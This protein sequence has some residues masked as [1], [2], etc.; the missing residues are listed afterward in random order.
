MFRFGWMGL[1]LAALVLWTGLGAGE[2]WGE[3]S[4]RVAGEQ[5]TVVEDGKP[6]FVLHGDM[7]AAPEGVPANF[8]RT[9]YLH[10]LYGL[11]GEVLTEDFPVDHRHH[12]GV[13]W[14]W[15]Q[16]MAGKRAMDVWTLKDARQVFDGWVAR[17][18]RDGVAH[19]VMRNMWVFDDAP[20]EPVLRETVSIAVHP[21]TAVGRA[22]DFTIELNNVSGQDF[23]LLGAKDK[24]YG[25]FCVRPPAARKPMTFTTATG[26]LTED[27]LRAATPWADV[28]F[29]V[30]AG[31]SAKSGVAI[32]QHPGNPAYPHDGWLMRH[33]SF[34]GAAWP[35]ETPHVIAHGATLT[36]RYRLYLHRGDAAAGQVAA[37]FAAYV[38][39]VGR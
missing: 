12:R 7:V 38:A 34:L 22:L 27:A 26:L 24:G 21:A 13:F 4:L 5:V 37:A 30:A 14:A 20:A 2:A 1:W 33:Y 16:G 39:E 6:V 18:V 19:V 31:D 36:L 10:P 23:S 8:R 9:A 35:H 32:F 3:F 17:E 11:D 29:A 15:P 25:G 28:S